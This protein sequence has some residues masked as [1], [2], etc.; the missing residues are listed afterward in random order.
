MDLNKF[1]THIHLSYRE[2]AQ[3]LL[4]LLSKVWRGRLIHLSLNNGGE[5]NEEILNFAEKL[6]EVKTT[7]VED[8]G[9]DQWGFI[10][11]FKDNEEDVE[12]ILYLHD[13]KDMAW[14]VRACGPL[15]NKSCE[16]FALMGEREIGLIGAQS[17]RKKI[18]SYEGV[19]AY[20]QPSRIKVIKEGGRIVWDMYKPNGSQVVRTLSTLCW[21][22]ILVRELASAFNIGTH[23]NIFEI[24]FPAGTIFMAKKQLVQVAHECVSDSFFESGHINDGKVE[25]ALERFYGYVC[26][27][28]NL[29]DVYI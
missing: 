29:R 20:H 18:L 15:L 28:L 7:L 22:Q 4:M 12:N 5:H 16:A 24:F 3:E 26:S 21:Y 9:T 8:M 13:K 11:S 14:M 6:F 19:L 27:S 10:N 25:H 17:V 2:P 1:S 23:R